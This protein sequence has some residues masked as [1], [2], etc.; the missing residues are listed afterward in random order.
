MRRNLVFAVGDKT[1]EHLDWANSCP[2]R[3]W[4]ITLSYFGPLGEAP[5]QFY[6]HVEPQGR[7][8]KWGSIFDYFNRNLPLLDSYDYVW[9]PDDDVR[10][11]PADIDR[12]FTLMRDY[13]FDIAQPSLTTNSYFSHLITLQQ[14]NYRVRSTDFVEVMM[15]CFRA[16]Y[17]NNL[18]PLIEGA[19]TGWGLDF[20][21][22]RDDLT[23]RS[24]I[25]DEIAMTH[26]RPIG[27]GDIYKVALQQGLG[28]IEQE[29][30]SA[31]DRF[32]YRSRLT[33]PR[34]GVRRDGT[35]IEN[36]WVALADFYFGLRQIHPEHVLK[37]RYRRRV[38]REVR[39]IARYYLT[40]GISRRVSVE[41]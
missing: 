31:I 34:G 25:F 39:R 21:W 26:A 10:C 40:G 23:K 2:S 29:M 6:D 14:P 8:V 7:G 38:G 30:D 5:A 17:L 19:Y 41:R 16:K 22:A 20:G 37:A 12:L 9:C 11:D 36:K 32:D 18:L 1:P 33:F 13:D 27:A 3:T 24:G 28:T 15:P 35:V 4:D